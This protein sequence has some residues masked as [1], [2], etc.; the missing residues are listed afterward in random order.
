[1]RRIRRV[2]KNRIE[3]TILKKHLLD[4]KDI[5]HSRIDFIND[6]GTSDKPAEVKTQITDHGDCYIYTQEFIQRI[7]RKPRLVEFKKLIS[8]LE[9]FE[10]EGFVHGDLNTKNILFSESGFRIIDYEISLRQLK[11]GQS[12]FMATRP[13]ISTAD[14]EHDKITVATDKKSFFCFILR[15][16]LNISVMCLEKEIFKSD[17]DLDLKLLGMSYNKIFDAAVRNYCEYTGK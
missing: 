17:P 11:D 6:L 12:V 16:Y 3:K 13:Y 1:M 14:L 4:P 9:Y 8:T 15:K 2:D 7:D 10:R 5:I